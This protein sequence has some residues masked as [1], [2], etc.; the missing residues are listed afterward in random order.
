[1]TEYLSVIRLNYGRKKTGR[2][3]Q[4]K[5]IIL[6]DE[7]R[8]RISSQISDTTTLMA[9]RSFNEQPLDKSCEPDRQEVPV[10]RNLSVTFTYAATF[11]GIPAGRYI[12]FRVR[13]TYLCVVAGISLVEGRYLLVRGFC[14]IATIKKRQTKRNNG[15]SAAKTRAKSRERIAKKAGLHRN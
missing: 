11:S 13:E 7:A 2:S 12:D 8:S 3:L 5:A 9:S 15:E 1:M 6:G 10:P 14:G 4:L